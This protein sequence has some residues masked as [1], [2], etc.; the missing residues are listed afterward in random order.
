M[1]PGTRDDDPRTAF[2]ADLTYQLAGPGIESVNDFIDQHRIQAPD[3]AAVQVFRQ[4]GWQ[5]FIQLKRRQRLPP[6]KYTINIQIQNGS[7]FITFSGDYP[8][9]QRTSQ[10]QFRRR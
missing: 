5:G 10:E 1:A 3:C 9:K 4:P 8:Q 2:L 6:G 7:H